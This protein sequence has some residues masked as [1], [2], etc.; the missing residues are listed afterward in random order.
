MTTQGSLV[1]TALPAVV[2]ALSLLTSFALATPPPLP[3]FPKLEF[4]PPKPETYT[5]PNG[6]TVYL[7]ED[8]E[9]PLIH[10]QTITRAGSQYEPADKLGI[11]DVFGA[12]MTEGGSAAQTPE[13]IEKL[14]DKTAASIG[15]SVSLESASGAMS[16]RSEDFKTIF[17]TFT[18]LFLHPLFRKDH[19]DL[20]RG[21]ALESLR[22]MNDEPEDMARREFRRL[23]YGTTHPYARIPSPQTLGAVRRDD[24]I[25]MHAGYFHP[26]ATYLAVSGD[27]KSAEMKKMIEAAFA[28]WPAVPMTLPPLPSVPSML[29]RGVYYINRPIKQSQIR[30]GH[31][32][33]ARHNPDHFA[34]E[35]FNE[36]WGGS[37]TSRLFSTVR[38]QLGLAYSVGSGY[39]EFAEQGMIVA[40][41][42]TRGS[43]TIAATQAI[44]KISADVRPAP[45]TAQEIQWAKESIQNRFVENYTSSAQIISE[46]MSF[47]YF[48]FPA[49]YLDTYPGQ[50][51]K[52]SGADLTRVGEKYLRPD[53]AKILLVGDLSTFDKPISTLGK[54]VEVKPIDYSQEAP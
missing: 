21:K 44:L 32:G 37:A 17:A 8:H 34:W 15:F 24:L 42:Q 18:G 23:N 7:L 43:Q 48:G 54:P 16:C 25:A 9:L 39:S 28:G 1:M 46:V 20:I 12:A 45:F 38:T 33:L 30:I 36:L 52:V 53:L 6:L 51:G 3:A 26:N 11:S 19:V 5:L 47:A 13:E 49:N 22:R 2:A 31:L 4:H 35:V 50:I 29:E 10:L 40:V 14:L 27:F 41:S